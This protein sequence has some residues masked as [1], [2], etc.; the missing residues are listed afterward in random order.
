MCVV[1]S[2]LYSCSVLRCLFRRQTI[3]DKDAELEFQVTT[4]PVDKTT[5]NELYSKC[6][7]VIKKIRKIM[8]LFH[9]S[10]TKN[11]TILQKYVMKMND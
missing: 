5:T 8:T 9:R 3:D 4:D 10:V 6:D 1:T 11:D 7:P 2:E